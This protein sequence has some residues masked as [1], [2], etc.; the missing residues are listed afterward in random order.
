METNSPQAESERPPAPRPEPLFELDLGDNGG[1]VAPSSF[2]ELSSWLQAEHSF[3]NWAIQRSQGNHEQGFRQAHSH[4]GQALQQLNEAQQH[5]TSNPEHSRNRL[6]TCKSQIEE[7]FLRRRLPHSSTPQAKRIDNYRQRA[8]DRA[9]S[10][11]LGTHVH[12]DQ[13]HHFQPNDLD[14]WRGLVEG[15]VEGFAT[16]DTLAQ[17]WTTGAGV[18]FEQL[19]VKAEELVGTKAVALDALHRQYA[20]ISSAV[21]STSTKQSDDFSAAQAERDK[22]F[23]SLLEE[24]KQG[25]ETL[26]KTFRE[27]IALRAP[28]DYWETKRK[29]HRT[30]AWITGGLSFAGIAGAALV[31]G[32]QIHD[33][34]ASTPSGRTP[35]T[36]RLAVLILIGL[37]AVWGVRLIVRMF[38]S[39]MHLMTDAGERVVMVKTYLSLLE[40]DRLASKE[41]RQLILQALFRPATDGI[42][43]DE[44]IPPSYL[45]MLTRNPKS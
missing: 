5:Q 29:G 33:L 45:E 11:M 25:V 27:E 32:W 4:L 30:L 12:P 9:A 2:E 1:L 41:D 20:S 17:D 3:W 35:D 39:H 14:S 26:R 21:E 43:K 19:R 22:A 10:F 24:H 37:F 18:S 34:L 16:V 42:V 38:L 6:A 40:G 31:L 36:W 44:G 13:G 8:G 23:A 7:A 15:I 28:A